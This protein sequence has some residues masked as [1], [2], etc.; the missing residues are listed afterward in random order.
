MCAAIVLKIPGETRKI[1]GPEKCGARRYSFA[2][3]IY[4]CRLCRS[5]R[6]NTYIDFGMRTDKP[7]CAS[8][9]WVCN[10]QNPFSRFEFLSVN[11]LKCSNATILNNV[12][13]FTIVT[14]RTTIS[15][16]TGGRRRRI[17]MS[18]TTQN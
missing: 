18:K 11:S 6:I 16:G 14:R 1:T 17:I 12:S 15:I 4:V 2:T 8:G 13:V 9:V 7:Y 5:K 10:L 3:I